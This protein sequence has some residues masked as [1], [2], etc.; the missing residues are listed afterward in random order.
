MVCGGYLG[1]ACGQLHMIWSCRVAPVGQLGMEGISAFYTGVTCH[2]G[3]S[4]VLTLTLTFV[5]MLNLLKVPILTQLLIMHC[6]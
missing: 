3:S 5:H 6:G 1:I 2:T 4:R